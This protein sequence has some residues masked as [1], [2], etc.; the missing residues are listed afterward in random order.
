MVGVTFALE[1]RIDANRRHDVGRGLFVELSLG[2]S[3]G[4]F[5]SNLQSVGTFLRGGFYIERVSQEHVLRPSDL[6]VIQE[7][8]RDGVD[9]FKTNRDKN[10]IAKWISI[11]HA[12]L[13]N[14]S[15][16]CLK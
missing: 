3:D 1:L 4:R 10:V 7:D 14:N 16:S 8:G 15:E 9:T 12:R 6:D 13:T 11:C 5:E 2:V